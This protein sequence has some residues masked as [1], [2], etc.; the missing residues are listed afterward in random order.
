[1]SKTLST[2]LVV[3]TIVILLIVKEKYPN[4]PIIGI[5]VGVGYLIGRFT[6]SDD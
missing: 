6:K 4:A 1:M 2:L 3:L 5:G